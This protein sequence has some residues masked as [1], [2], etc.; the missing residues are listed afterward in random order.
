MPQMESDLQALLEPK[1][2]ARERIA[3]LAKQERQQHV[4]RVRLSRIYRGIIDSDESV[5]KVVE[6]LREHLIKL[7]AENARIIL[8]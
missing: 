5:E 3:E 8:K 4:E 1:A 6:A 7:L 2:M